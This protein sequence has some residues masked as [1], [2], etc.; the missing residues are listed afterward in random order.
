LLGICVRGVACRLSV[1]S[2]RWRTARTGGVSDHSRQT[3]TFAAPAPAVDLCIDGTLMKWYRGDG[4]MRTSGRNPFKAPEIKNSCPY[5]IGTRPAP[6]RDGLS[7]RS[8]DCTASVR[9]HGARIEA[10]SVQVLQ[11]TRAVFSRCLYRT[12]L[13]LEGY[14]GALSLSRA[15]LFIPTD[16]SIYRFEEKLIGPDVPMIVKQFSRFCGSIGPRIDRRMM[17]TLCKQGS[18]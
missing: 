5:E 12:G 7:I 17:A 8:E 11:P 6:L 9:I 1:A 15:E 14:N 2:I 10:V 4:L 18:N 3:Q 16:T 13:F